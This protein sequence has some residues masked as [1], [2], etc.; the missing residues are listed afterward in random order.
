MSQVLLNKI[1]TAEKKQR[2]YRL[3]VQDVDE[4]GFPID[5]YTV[6]QSPISIKF[7]VNRSLFAD[8]NTLDIDIY[9]LAP[10]TYRKLFFDFFNMKYR[11][12]TL[13]AGYESTGLSVIFM[14]EMWSCYTHREKCDVI[15]KMHCIVGL[16][17]M[18]A[19]TDITLAGIHRD[20]VLA[21]VASDMALELQIYS[22]DDKIITRSVVLSDNS[23]AI[24][25]QY[26]D[27]NAFIDNGRLIILKDTD[28]IKGYV[29]LI[30]DESGL[31]G[32]PKHE[33]AILKIDMIFEPRII[34]GQIIEVNSRILPM[35][36]GQY[37]VFGVKHA[38]I[39]SGATAG[40]VVTTLEMLVGSQ[41]YGRF[42]IVT[43]K[44]Q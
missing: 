41:I 37:K 21:R 5:D 32:V 15:T 6:I 4:N 18:Q 26:S 40:S 8:V 35:F 16:K 20:K 13:E 34:V 29:P 38:G 2:V 9:N 1:S 25:Q 30:N 7:S 17:S 43:L 27:N 3:T 14:G 36:N 19:R 31:L 24:A 22:T 23:M 44:H 12:V 39:I 11:K 10:Q 33:D 42:G 28:A